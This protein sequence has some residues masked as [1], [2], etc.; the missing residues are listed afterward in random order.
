VHCREVCV[1][2]VRR[3]FRAPSGAPAL[4][5]PPQ[6]RS[7]LRVGMGRHSHGFPC[8]DVCWGNFA[9]AT[10]HSLSGTSLFFPQEQTPAVTGCPWTQT[11]AATAF[12][13]QLWAS[14][15]LHILGTRHVNWLE[16]AVTP[17][18]PSSLP[19]FPSTLS[20]RPLPLPRPPRQ[21][22][23]DTSSV[24]S[25]FSPELTLCLAGL[26]WGHCSQEIWSQLSTLQKDNFHGTLSFSKAGTEPVKPRVSGP[27]PVAGHEASYHT[28]SV[29]PMWQVSPCHRFLFPCSLKKTTETSDKRCC[30]LQVPGKC[31]HD[32][33]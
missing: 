17:V 30:E 22:S 13:R 1:S 29:S 16:E 23:R 32:S 7:D 26:Q 31:Y 15:G 5:Y 25:A 11:S 9:T 20:L 4:F 18:V 10:V 3:W 21:D 33:G 24:V 14:S 28:D 27:V 12:R 2:E 6:I 8:S 19:S